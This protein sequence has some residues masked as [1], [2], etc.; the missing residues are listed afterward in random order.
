MGPRSY[1]DALGFAKTSL[2][3]KGVAVIVTSTTGLLAA[4]ATR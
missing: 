3:S 4:A 2:R 1:T